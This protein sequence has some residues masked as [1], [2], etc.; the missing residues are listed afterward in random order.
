MMTKEDV[1]NC[2]FTHNFVK[3]RVLFIPTFWLVFPRHS[4]SIWAIPDQN[5]MRHPSHAEIY[6]T[7][8]TENMNN[9]VGG[10]KPFESYHNH[11]PRPDDV[12]GGVGKI[13]HAR[14]FLNLRVLF[15]VALKSALRINFRTFLVDGLR[16]ALLILKV[17]KKREQ[18]KSLV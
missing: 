13:S 4:M 1:G 9:F 5:T 10:R 3:L 2:L 6:A 18:K 8:D 11:N 12:K 15:F 7:R 14:N 16:P 17:V